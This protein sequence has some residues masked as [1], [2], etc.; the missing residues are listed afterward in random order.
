MHCQAGQPKP[1]MAFDLHFFKT[2]K[3][4]LPRFTELIFGVLFIFPFFLPRIQSQRKWIIK[5][6]QV[7]V[8]CL[9]LLIVFLRSGPWTCSILCGSLQQTDCVS[10]QIQSKFCDNQS[11]T[12]RRYVRIQCGIGLVT[13]S[14]P[15]TTTMMMINDGWRSMTLLGLWSA[16]LFPRANKSTQCGICPRTRMFYSV[17]APTDRVKLTNKRLHI[18]RST[19]FQN[20]F[21]CSISWFASYSC[22]HLW[23]NNVRTHTHT[24]D[25]FGTQGPGCPMDGPIMVAV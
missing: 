25:P 12:S 11:V 1:A 18:D 10:G 23:V 21:P 22:F 5:C 9:V 15:K 3:Q 7:C 2:R 6:N 16:R 17:E 24:I 20:D 19:I 8:L 14:L 13:S 4:S